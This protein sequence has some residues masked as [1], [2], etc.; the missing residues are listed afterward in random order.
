ML[1]LK[2]TEQIGNGPKDI[3]FMLSVRDHSQIGRLHDNTRIIL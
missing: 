1:R 3:F 2:G